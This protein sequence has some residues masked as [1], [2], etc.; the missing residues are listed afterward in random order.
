MNEE[1]DEF[2][3][4]KK[5]YMNKKTN[6]C[7]NCNRAVGTHFKVEY[8]SDKRILKIDCG[9]KDNPCDLKKEVVV[10][11]TFNRD[12]Y[13]RELEVKKKEIEDEIMKL[14]NKLLYEL[15][16]ETQYNKLFEEINN[17]YKKIVK[18]IETASANV[19][20][21]DMK[22]LSIKNKLSEE[23]ENN[24]EIEDEYDKMYNIINKIKP[25]SSL[26]Q[27]NLILLKEENDVYRLREKI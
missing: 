20:K 12:D 21:E 3:M 4:L 25:I 17:E 19:D 9:D 6:R 18:E 8:F 7:I 2:Y 27:D 13:I 24:L 23:I 22:R 1:I 11:K 15:I 10:L 14:K 16:S 26:Y 5:N